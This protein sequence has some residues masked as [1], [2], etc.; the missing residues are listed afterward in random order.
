M[1]ITNQN[2]LLTKS[3]QIALGALLLAPIQSHA[4][5]ITN[6]TGI[7]RIFTSAAPFQIIGRMHGE[8]AH[9]DSAGCDPMNTDCHDHGSI[10]TP[11]KDAAC[12]A[13]AKLPPHPNNNTYR[14]TLHAYTFDFDTTE[15]FTPEDIAANI[16]TTH[17]YDYMYS[18]PISCATIGFP[19]PTKPFECIA[20]AKR[21]TTGQIAL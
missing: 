5:L 6:E 14:V 9:G 15:Q 3:L 7:S 8:L 13:F 11:T 19:I 2:R 18:A 1:N 16:H 4:F 20:A 10:V 21:C 17:S 12:M